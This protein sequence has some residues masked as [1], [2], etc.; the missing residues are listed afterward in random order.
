MATVELGERISYEVVEDDFS[1]DSL[2]QTVREGF[3]ETPRKLPPWV[4]YDGR[5]S[6]LYREICGLSDY[7]PATKERWILKN[8]AD[9]IVEELNYPKRVTELGCGS[10]EKTRG[11]LSKLIEA[12][13]TLEYEMIDISD[14]QLR[15]A[16]EDV[17]AEFDSLSV[18]AVA[19]DYISGLQRLPDLADQRLL[20]FLGGSLGNFE[21]EDAQQF[22]GTVKEAADSSAGMLVGV[23][24]VKEPSVIETAYNDSEGVTAKFN[25]NVLRRINRELGGRFDPETFRHEAPFVEEKS[26]IEMRLV[27]EVDQSVY[28]EGLSQSY[29]FDQGDYIHT[30]SSN[31]Y[32]LERFEDLVNGADYDLERYWTDPDDY[33][34][35]TLLKPR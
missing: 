32:T 4:L 18:T 25:K 22:L 35:L 21:P 14:D 9:E 31:K 29:D 5:G 20:F 24:L 27:S 6:E 19:G 7:Y 28:V 23:D 12:N 1:R 10:A 3:E 33:F 13:D 16:A 11:I 15:K 2:A 30:E 34:A 17:V 8:F 26:R